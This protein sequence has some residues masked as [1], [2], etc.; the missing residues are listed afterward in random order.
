MFNSLTDA[1]AN[2]L[3]EEE[4]FMVNAATCAFIAMEHSASPLIAAVFSLSTALW[5]NKTD[6]GYPAFELVAPCPLYFIVY[7]A[8]NLKSYLNRT[9]RVILPSP[10]WMIEGHCLGDF[11]LEELVA[12]QTSSSTWVSFIFFRS[13]HSLVHSNC[14]TFE[15]VSICAIISTASFTYPHKKNCHG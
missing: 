2:T 1:Y 8:P 13:V 6:I 12:K 7:G 11:G 10:I 15:A 3:S 5:A 9:P 4:A 14:C